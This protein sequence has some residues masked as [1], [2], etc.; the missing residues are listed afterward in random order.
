MNGAPSVLLVYVSGDGCEGIQVTA[1]VILAVDAGVGLAVGT[2]VAVVCVV[3]RVVAGILVVWVVTGDAVTGTV[4]ERGVAG[5]GTAV[6]M[7]N[8]S[9][10]RAVMPAVADTGIMGPE[11]F[12]AAFPAISRSRGIERDPATTMI[13][14]ITAAAAAPV[15]ADLPVR[16][17]GGRSGNLVPH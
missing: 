4:V 11:G 8:G 15:T 5:D 16:R 1:R 10:G 2:V 17:A 14:I 9:E 3:F 12:P 13:A 7:G 6:V